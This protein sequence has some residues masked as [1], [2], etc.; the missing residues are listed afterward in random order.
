M[1]ATIKPPI[2]YYEF[3]IIQ[4][5]SKCDYIM[6]QIK[7]I[8]LTNIVL[9]ITVAIISS[10]VN[11]TLQQLKNQ[12]EDSQ[13]LINSFNN[14]L[15]LLSSASSII[16]KLSDDRLNNIT[17]LINIL[18]KTDEIT[19]QITIL[20]QSIN[21][22]SLNLETA[23]D[24]INNQLT[25]MRGDINSFNS[26]LLSLNY[27]V[28]SFELT[29]DHQNQTTVQ[30]LINLNQIMNQQYSKINQT[31]S[32]LNNS[33]SLSDDQT[34]QMLLNSTSVIEDQLNKLNNF[35]INTNVIRTNHW[36][37]NINVALGALNT[38]SYVINL[39]HSYNDSDF[40]VININSVTASCSPTQYQ[41]CYG[42]QAIRS[43]NAIFSFYGEIDSI[44]SIPNIYL[45]FSYYINGLE[46]YGGAGSGS[47]SIVG[48]IVIPY[49]FL[50]G[51]ILSFIIYVSPYLGGYT[52]IYNLFYSELNATLN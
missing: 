19:S 31:I 24:S 7:T 36:P 8:N 35:V 6:Y 21:I 14:Q 16:D 4:F 11:T 39:G 9:L 26:Q 1:E 45:K 18:N 30:Q 49:N 33:L 37:L 17:Q 43:V 28:N 29:I 48:N 12:N 34:N 22:I 42:I 20:N 10:S 3:P 38:G 50:Q 47:S 51:D 15:S 23:I 40:Q 44:S 46:V 5:R 52:L 41:I 13:S 27:S 25:T 2:S 32:S